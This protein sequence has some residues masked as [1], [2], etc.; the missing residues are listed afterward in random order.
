MCVDCVCVCVCVCVL[1]L[2][3]SRDDSVE[4]VQ[5]GVTR[6]L[7]YSEMRKLSRTGSEKDY[8]RIAAHAL[9]KYPELW[10]NDERRPLSMGS[11]SGVDGFVDGMVSDLQARLTA[12]APVLGGGRLLGQARPRT[13][14]DLVREACSD[15]VME[16]ASVELQR[17]FRSILY[18]YVEFG[19]MLFSMLP[20]TP[21]PYGEIEFA[22]RTIQETAPYI[23]VSDTTSAEALASF[24]GRYWRLH[25]TDVIISVNG[26]ARDLHVSP[27]LDRVFRRGITELA[28]MSAMPLFVSG[29]T[30]DGVMKYLGDIMRQNALERKIV[31]V[32][33][34]GALA[35]QRRGCASR[36]IDLS[37]R[38]GKVPFNSA[39]KPEGRQTNLNP[40]HTHFILVHNR[41]EG[42]NVSS[43][44][45]G[46][47]VSLRTAVE[48]AYARQLNVPVMQLLVSGGPNSLFGV[49]SAMTNDIPVVAVAD[50]GGCCAALYEYIEGRCAGTTERVP[51]MFQDDERV[52]SRNAYDVGKP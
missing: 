12:E 3:A 34:Y 10:A 1:Q 14:A 42:D 27:R 25:P 7:K 44:P 5:A 49:Y 29:G 6:A 2:S 16:L 38:G 18:M 20:G 51:S 35:H 19:P 36:L 52:V 15:L 39:H 37:R 32:A 46:C 11:T 28:S 4:G 21:A 33:A 22:S 48:S 47:E 8:A 13:A 50:S 30:N 41:W 45:Y 17:R 43:P 24:M 26:A 23:C 31:G 40:D 9:R